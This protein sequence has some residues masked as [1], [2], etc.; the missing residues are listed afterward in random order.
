MYFTR[1]RTLD[2][3]YYFFFK[4]QKAAL[5]NLLQSWGVGILVV[6]E[7]LWGKQNTPEAD[8]SLIPQLWM[9]E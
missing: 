3:D 1:N 7:K 6:T 4:D 9:A 8:Q 2:T 5:S